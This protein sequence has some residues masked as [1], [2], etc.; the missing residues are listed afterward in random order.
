MI[1]IG[2]KPADPP[3]RRLEIIVADD[4]QEIKDLVTIWLEEEGHVVTHASNGREALQLVMGKSCDLLITDIVMPDGDGWDAIVALNR[5]RPHT[6][7]LAISGGGNHMPSDICL[8]VAKGVGADGILK[9][10]FR[11]AQFLTAVEQVMS[12]K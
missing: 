10:P 4:V 8:R 6:R 5:T 7:I 1:P 3:P 11:R 9:K 2:K 12:R